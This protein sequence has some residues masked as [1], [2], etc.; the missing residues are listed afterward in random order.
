MDDR[1]HFQ[2]EQVALILVVS[3][4][5]PCK[6]TSA[7]P[8]SGNSNGCVEQRTPCTARPSRPKCAG[9]RCHAVLIL[10]LC[11][12]SAARRK[13]RS[14]IMGKSLVA[15]QQVSLHRLLVVRN[16]QIG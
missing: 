8:H 10:L 2:P 4:A 3:A 1:G 15:P 16:C 5:P 11:P 7:A 12:Q 14:K 13:Q 6:P 9:N